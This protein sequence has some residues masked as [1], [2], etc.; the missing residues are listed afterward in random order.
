VRLSQRSR[1]QS[2]QRRNLTA[3]MRST[4]ND[5]FLPQ[6]QQV[7]SIILSVLCAIGVH[8]NRITE[9]RKSSGIQCLKRAKT[10]HLAYSCDLGRTPLTKQDRE[11]R[12]A[13][14]ER[15]EAARELLGLS[16]SQ[17]AD[18]IGISRPAYT[19]WIKGTHAPTPENLDALCTVS[20]QPISFFVGEAPTTEIA[21]FERELI[22][23]VGPKAAL[24]LLDLTE[25]EFRGRLA[26]KSAS[27]GEME[28]VIRG[29]LDERE[30]TQ[31]LSILMRADAVGL[32]QP[33][34]LAGMRALVEAVES[35]RGEDAAD[36][37]K[38]ERRARRLAQGGRR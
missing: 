1:A 20:R 33:S 2:Q 24:E 29:I 15:I 13:I 21:S 7:Q 19:S 9:N 12:A 32:D 22:R 14:G 16:K 27:A 38:L 10:G 28:S 30:I 25:G 31:L 5:H 4:R 34:Y 36:V 6:S 26:S 11:R 8:L 23:R 37:R 35:S 3:R 17:F 18:A